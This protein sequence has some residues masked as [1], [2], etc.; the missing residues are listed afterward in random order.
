[1]TYEIRMVERA[2]F[3]NERSNPVDGYRVTFAMPDGTVDWVEVP[4]AQYQPAVVKAQ[5]EALIKQHQA[6]RAT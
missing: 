3:L 6:M 5:I 2:T 1:M 4:K